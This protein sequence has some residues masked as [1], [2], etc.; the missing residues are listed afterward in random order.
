MEAINESIPYVKHRYCCRHIYNN[1]KGRH[2]SLLIRNNLWLAASSYNAPMFDV[3]MR[4]FKDIN[5]EALAWLEKLDVSTWAR[6]A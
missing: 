6:H 4:R 1:L 3:A 5:P 2:P